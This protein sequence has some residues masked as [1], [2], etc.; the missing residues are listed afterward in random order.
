M[1]PTIQHHLTNWVDGMKIN[2]QHFL[3]SENAFIDQ[4]RDGNSIALRN[5]S[6]GLL[7]PSNGEKNAI[8]CD[9]L[10]AQSSNFKIII[11][12]CR[13]VTSGGNRIE[14]IPGT[15]PELASDRS[16][17]S[18]QDTI[19]NGEAYLAVISVNPFIRTPFGNAIADEYPPRNQFSMAQYNLNL[20]AENNFN[21]STIGANH[22]PIA[23]FLSK[24]DE[25][26][27]DANYIPPCTTLTAHPGTRQL[28]NTI[29]QYYENIQQYCIEII[30]KVENNNQQTPLA[31]NLA[32]ICKHLVMHI[33]SNFFMFRTVY[34]QQSPIYL[35]D[36]VYK[37]TSMINTSLN[38]LSV[39]DKEELLSYFS[40]WNELSPGKF[41]DM[42]SEVI[43]ADYS[44]ENINTY[45]NPALAFLKI[46]TK[47][48]ED[49]KNLKLIG[50]KSKNSIFDGGR[51]GETN[52]PQFEAPQRKKSIFD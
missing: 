49:L 12:Q 50:E 39:R 32:E 45:F 48:L 37:I 52:K 38:F 51:I 35:A 19:T 26:V 22:L 9:I 20:I 36:N 23:R 28:G 8:S 25:L 27:S 41:S 29:G 17:F 4:I 14:I 1:T 44:H 43:N 42:L 13:A 31:K 46:W 10:N 6:Y 3:D 2:K 21:A 24:N 47:L 30:Q 7:E 34:Y 5:F 33:S 11:S 15:H 40:F 16:T 18:K